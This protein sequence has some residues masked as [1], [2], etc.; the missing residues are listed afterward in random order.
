MTFHL[1]KRIGR[2]CSLSN[3]ARV[4][5]PQLLLPRVLLSQ[6]L[7]PRLLPLQL[8]LHSYTVAMVAVVEVLLQIASDNVIRLD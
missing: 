7:L 5:L 6:L 1:Q 4:I 3:A 2:F 8:L